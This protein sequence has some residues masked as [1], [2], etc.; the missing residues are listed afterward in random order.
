MKGQSPAVAAPD[1]WRD[2]QAGDAAGLA[3]RAGIDVELSTVDTFGGPLV[4]AVRAGAVDEALVDRALRLVGAEREVGHCRQ[5]QSVARA[6][7]AAAPGH[8]PREARG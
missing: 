6:E 8:N 5:L 3:L 4:E 1:R 2:T 7:R